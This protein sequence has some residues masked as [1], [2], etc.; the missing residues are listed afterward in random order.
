MLSFTLLGHAE[1][2]LNGEPLRRFRSQKELALLCYLA[3]TGQAHRRDLIADLLWESDSSKQ[4][5]SN[6]R[7]VL[8]RVQQQVGDDLLVAPRSLELAPESRNDVDSRRLLETLAS[9]GAI[10]SPAAANTADG[11]L[12]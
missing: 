12:A 6:L 7:T 11:A 2:L 8:A 5:L 9:V 3:H 4:A 1:L 10:S